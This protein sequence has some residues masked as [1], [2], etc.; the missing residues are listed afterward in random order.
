MQL[1]KHIWMDTDTTPQGET[2]RYSV[3]LSAVTFVEKAVLDN[4]RYLDEILLHHKVKNLRDLR[5][6]LSEAMT[7]VTHLINSELEKN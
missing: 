4:A 6:A 2:I 5:I 3:N 1:T 7:E